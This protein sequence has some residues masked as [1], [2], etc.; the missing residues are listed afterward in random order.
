MTVLNRPWTNGTPG[1]THHQRPERK[2][3]LLAKAV[4][5]D[6]RASLKNKNKKKHKNKKTPKK[7][8]SLVQKKISAKRPGLDVAAEP[9]SPLGR[10][11]QVCS[12]RWR[13]SRDLTDETVDRSCPS[14]T[15]SVTTLVKALLAHDLLLPSPFAELH[16]AAAIHIS[17]FQRTV[18]TQPQ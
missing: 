3:T 16:P 5:E 11:Q 10:N 14:R 2:H 9:K 7:F 6:L 17:S 15:Y 4:R 1:K 12:Q 13:Q 18:D 8:F